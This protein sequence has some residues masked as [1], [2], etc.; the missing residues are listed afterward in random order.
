MLMQQSMIHRKYHGKTGYLLRNVDV[1]IREFVGMGYCVDDMQMM[2]TDE[3]QMMTS[4][5]SCTSQ[6]H[7]SIAQ[8]NHTKQ[9]DVTSK[10]G[11]TN[12]AFG[13]SRATQVHMEDLRLV[14]LTELHPS[15]RVEHFKTPC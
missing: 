12:D 1:G 3:L 7:K 2:W 10:N 13:C 5:G 4:C 14:N 6:S 9:D 15:Q 11:K 8:T